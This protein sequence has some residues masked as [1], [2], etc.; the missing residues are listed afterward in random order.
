MTCSFCDDDEVTVGVGHDPST[1]PVDENGE[2]R[3]CRRHL[4]EWE[5]TEF[6]QDPYRVLPGSPAPELTR[7]ASHDAV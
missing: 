2:T 7:D 3:F 6:A 4:T 1:T 5:R